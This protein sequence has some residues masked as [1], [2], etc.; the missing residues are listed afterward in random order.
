MI[1]N[2]AQLAGKILASNFKRLPLPYKLTFAVTYRCNSRCKTCNIWKKKSNNELTLQEIEKIF[3]KTNSFSWISVT[4]GEPSLRNDFAD[5]CKIIS[6]YCKNIVLLHFSTNGLLIDKI[7][8]DVEKIRGFNTSSKIIITVSTDGDELL[9]D[10]IRGIKGAWKK[11][12]ETFKQLNKIP[13][14][15]PVL[16]MTLSPY[17]YDKFHETYSALQHAIPDFTAK[18]FHINVFNFSDNYYNNAELKNLY[19]DSPDNISK[20]TKGVIRSTQEYRKLLG[21]W[22]NPRTILERIYLQR[23]FSFLTTGKTP[24][25]CHALRSSC[26]IDPYGEIYPCITYNRTLGNLRDFNY[27][28]KKIWDKEST[29]QINKEIRRFA[30]PQCWTGC[31]GYQTILGNLSRILYPTFKD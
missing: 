15:E 13:N 30:C 2:Y 25:P 6:T 12:L 31:D 9:N 28:L 8:N 7:I 3:I 29:I 11:Q 4:G 22:K 21:G 19:A 23:S 27:D 1:T 10:D 16:G 5:I 18:N 20:I 17:N 26:F 24:L 14:V